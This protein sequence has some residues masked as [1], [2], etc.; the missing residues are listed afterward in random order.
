MLHFSSH[1]HP[2]ALAKV[3]TKKADSKSAHL[4]TAKHSD[5][6][7]DIFWEDKV[8]WDYKLKSRYALFL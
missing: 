3:V 6:K 4:V 5:L 1:S 7:E 8:L 2:L